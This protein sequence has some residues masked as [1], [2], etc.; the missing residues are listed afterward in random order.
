MKATKHP[1]A[2]LQLLNFSGTDGERALN[3]DVRDLLLPADP[4]IWKSQARRP[5]W[6]RSI[7]VDCVLNLFGPPP[8]GLQDTGLASWIAD[9]Q[10]TRLP[11]FC[12]EQEC[13]DRDTVFRRIL[14]LSHRVVLSS[15]D[16]ERDCRRFE[17]ASGDKLRVCSFPSGF[18]FQD[19]PELESGA[20]CRKYHLPEKFVLVAN[21]FWAHKNHLSVIESARL[22]AER[23]IQ[24]PFVLT[25]LPADYRDPSNQLVSK[26][27]QGIACY[28]LRNQVVPL[29]QVPYLDL[30]A[31]LRHA[32]IIVQ[33]SSFEGW[34]TTV[35]D[36]KA[37]GR[38]VACSS[39]SLHREQA[40]GAMGFFDPK[41]PQ[42]LA[43]LLEQHWPQLTAG[44][45]LTAE[46]RCL[47][48]EREFA[49]DYGT[50]LWQ[51]CAEAAAAAR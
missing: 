25:G 22:L 7:Q 17:P 1:Q 47:T 35:Q 20:I 43:D 37:L 21:Q 4:E 34:S 2:K 42:Q 27:L 44:P 11:Q 8:E 30:I 36:A 13:R 23:G 12:S 49:R 40:P 32:A 26:V 18:A 45:D 6:L 15:H 38:P 16:A 46:T 10:H 3:A 14:A 50:A 33:P 24:I 31:L 9:F 39:I 51:T 41:Q 29:A 48:M 5:D 28:G 19:M